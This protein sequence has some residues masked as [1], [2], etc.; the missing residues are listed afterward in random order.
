MPE[1]KY[2]IFSYPLI[3][4]QPFLEDSPLSTLTVSSDMKG[5]HFEDLAAGHRAS[6]AVLGT[7]SA[8]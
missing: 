2:H 4:L 8:T 7:L 3:F 6:H 1:G 5:L